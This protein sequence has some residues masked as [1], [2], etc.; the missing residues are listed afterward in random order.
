MALK[1]IRDT[2]DETH[3]VVRIVSNQVYQQTSD[4]F[5]VRRVTHLFLRRLLSP[6]SSQTLWGRR[7]APSPG[8]GLSYVTDASSSG[9]GLISTSTITNIEHYN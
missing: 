8:S 1:A 7:P 6:R 3:R 2:V 4:I 9:S 5:T